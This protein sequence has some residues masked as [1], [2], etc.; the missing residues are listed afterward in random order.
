MDPT[1][2]PSLAGV[3]PESESHFSGIGSPIGLCRFLKR[4]C[5]ESGQIHFFAGIARS[6][7]RIFEES[8]HLYDRLAKAASDLLVEG[9]GPFLPLPKSEIKTHQ[10]E[11]SRFLKNATP[12]PGDSCEKVDLTRLLAIP[13]KASVQPYR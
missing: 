9:P 1:P 13:L 5:K 10:I 11:V 3:A 2:N 12:T 6:R 4:N 7:S 8:A